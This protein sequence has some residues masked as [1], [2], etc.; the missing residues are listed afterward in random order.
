MSVMVLL[1]TALASQ[2]A[3]SPSLRDPPIVGDVPKPNTYLDGD[4]WTARAG[5]VVVPST[6]PGDIITDLQR[7]GMVGDP[8]YGVNWREQ[9]G[10]WAKESGWSF[11]RI[12]DYRTVASPSV[13]LVLDGV[14]M[15]AD[16][17]LNG[18]HLG[19]LADQHLRY[20]FEI[21]HM[22][23]TTANN[24]TIHIPLPSHD[25]RNDEGRYAACS[26]G[27]DWAQYSNTFTPGGLPW[28][29]FGVW[30]SVYLVEVATFSLRA[31]VPH[32]FYNGAYPT[33]P[34]TDATAS[35]WSVNVTAHIVAGPKGTPVGVGMFSASIAGLDIP[36]ATGTLGKALQPNEAFN[37]TLTL[38]VP[39]RMVRLWWPN[40]VAAA[41][42][43]KQPLYTISLSY[44]S[45]NTTE[46]KDKAVFVT[47]KKIGFRTLAAVTDDDSKPSRI[48]NLSGSGSLVLRYVV[49]GAS[50]WIRGSNVIPLDEFAGRADP[51]ALRLQLESAA[52]AGMNMLL[53]WGGGIFQYTVF[54][55][56][57]DKLGLLLYHDLMYSAQQQ[58]S[59]LCTATE[60]Q[61]REIV[62]NVRRLFSHPSIAV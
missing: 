35:G 16:V 38:S 49:N 61:L 33:M 23:R 3:M 7:A 44:H 52:A 59:H 39:P 60:M 30:K 26:G 1:Q 22:L 21:I 8:M 55:E 54:Y 2:A 27:W 57:A 47:S 62:Y 50:L 48:A 32:V 20:E 36:A 37:I 51:E 29:S 4:K 24:I 13:L 10:V 40:G 45:K 43:S 28:L 46:G 41:R 17:Y 6:V 5:K 9:S 58:S 15:A 18:V 25:V 53:I 42:A 34:L 14:K 56:M 19:G 11:T 12:F 31:M